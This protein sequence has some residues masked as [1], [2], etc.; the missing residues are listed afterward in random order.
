MKRR[1]C[2]WNWGAIGCV[3]FLVVFWS[4]V[5]CAIC[6]ADETNINMTR[7]AMIESSGNPKA[8]NKRT[9]AR[10]MYQIRKIVVDDY[11]QYHEDKIFFNQMF[12]K[13]VN[14]HV[15]SW[16]LSNRI[17]SMLRYFKIPTNELTIIAAYNWGIG[18]VKK[19]YR[20]GGQFE[21]LPT[22]TQNYYRKYKRGV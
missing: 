3:I 4:L 6:N 17:P 15:A 9:D 5:V 18:N 16:Y 8:W 10:G 1:P 7:I 13:S 14:E 19:W 11:N 22:E 20:N 21:S 12:D 2:E